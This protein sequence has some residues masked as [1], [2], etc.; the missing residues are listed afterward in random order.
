M[1]SIFSALREA[2]A[3]AENG[4]IERLDAREQRAVGV[5]QEPESAAAIGVDQIEKRGAFFVHLPGAVGFE[6]E[7][8][9]DAERGFALRPKS[10]GE[11]P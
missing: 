5:H 1:N 11:T 3:F 7:K 8:F 10:C 4:E 6:A 2:N 9:A